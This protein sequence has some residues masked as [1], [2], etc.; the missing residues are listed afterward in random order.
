MD[1]LIASVSF[2]V[3]EV[4]ENG[5]VQVVTDKVKLASQV[6]LTSNTEDATLEFILKES[7]DE[8]NALT[9]LDNIK[10]EVN[11]MVRLVHFYQETGKDVLYKVSL[12]TVFTGN[13]GTGKTIV[14]I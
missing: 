5:L 11:E 10:Q 13:P 7:L 9:G 1:M 8:L 3:G 12:H 2:K 14:G 4:F 6:G